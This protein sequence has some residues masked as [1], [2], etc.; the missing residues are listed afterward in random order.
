MKA[1]VHALAAASIALAPRLA[2]AHG[3]AAERA[4]HADQAVSASP[5]DPQPLVARAELFLDA[6]DPEAAVDD[7][8][9]AATAAGGCVGSPRSTT[10]SR[11]DRL[12]AEAY[13]AADDGGAAA[14]VIERLLVDS[15]SDPRALYLR[16]RLAAADA[17]YRDAARDLAASLDA[18]RDP[19]ASAYLELAGLHV[20]DGDDDAAMAAIESGVSRLG[21]LV[22]LVD[23]AIDIEMRRGRP[24]EALAWT[25]RWE[26]RMRSSPAGR[27]LR[28]ELLV[29]LGRAADAETEASL[30]LADIEALPK[31][32]RASSAIVS[33][34]ARLRA[35][36]DAART[37]SAPPSEPRPLTGPILA[38]AAALLSASAFRWL[39][40]RRSGPRPA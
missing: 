11:I 30:G 24:A 2:S 38:F 17:R 29:S 13:L 6:G 7:L 25:D 20:D 21:P 34:Q 27:A 39:G 31:A 32:R 35:T 9:R 4:S 8:E 26:E 37:P 5:G 40:R 16:A 19:A 1:F 22:V 12:L 28:A 10:C 14:E 15:A 36:V 18:T 3:S 23:A 33:V